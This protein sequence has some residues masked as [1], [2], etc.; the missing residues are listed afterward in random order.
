MIISKIDGVCMV[1]PKWII[2]AHK[3]FYL[4]TIGKFLIRSFKNFLF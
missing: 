4:L 1:Q 3:N 2:L